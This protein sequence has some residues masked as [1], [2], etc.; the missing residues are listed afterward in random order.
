MKRILAL[1]L[2]IVLLA[3][4]LMGCGA[5][6]KLTGTWHATA[7]LSHVLQGIV[8]EKLPNTVLEVPEFP[9]T[10]ELTF[11]KDNT[12]TFT[13]DEPS[14]EAALEQML[15]TVKQ[16]FVDSLKDQLVLMDRDVSL[17]ELLKY[18][19]VDLQSLVDG[20]DA[21]VK[22][23]DLAGELTE[24]MTFN[25]YFK[26]SDEKLYIS[27]TEEIDKEGFAFVY[28]NEEGVL[29]LPMIY[30][31]SPMALELTAAICPLS[32]QKVK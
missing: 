8:A 7:D 12:C 29:T 25:G 22:K 27:T 2:T 21:A 24:H 28:K 32:F 19:G 1:I 17:E 3:A 20:F 9:V 4:T 10:L 31:D 14:V 13:L 26:L 23:A 5:K 6:G 16:A 15:P 18:I 30:N 11:R